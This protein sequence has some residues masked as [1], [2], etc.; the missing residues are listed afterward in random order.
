MQRAVDPESLS[1]Q[2][3]VMIPPEEPSR[4]ERALDIA[5]SFAKPLA[6]VAGAGYGGVQGYMSGGWPGAGIGA[7]HGLKQGWA[8]GKK[9]EDFIGK[10][11]TTAKNLK[12]AFTPGASGANDYFD[13]DEEF[14]TPGFKRPKHRASSK[15]NRYEYRG[16]RSRSG[17]SS[18]Y[19]PMYQDYRNP[20]SM[21]TRP[22]TYY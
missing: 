6:A 16:P 10:V 12:R 14:Y 2:L 18:S 13:V 17:Y 20:Y 3:A 15:S 22:L 9:G 8:L 7:A 19:S 11:G 1:G 5:K 4:W 21:Y